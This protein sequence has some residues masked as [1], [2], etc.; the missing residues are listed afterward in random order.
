MGG[1]GFFRF[2]SGPRI[3]CAAHRDQGN[4][5]PFAPNTIQEEPR[6]RQRTIAALTLLFTIATVPEPGCAADLIFVEGDPLGDL[7]VLA[8]PQAVMTFGRFIKSW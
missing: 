8:A 4:S 1:A 2:R 7:G 6:V 5:T 3:Y